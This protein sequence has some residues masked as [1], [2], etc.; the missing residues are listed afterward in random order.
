MSEPLRILAV[1]DTWCGA[2]DYGFVRAFRRTG[3]SV[4]VVSQQSFVPPGWRHPGLRALR[5]VLTPLIVRDLERRLIHEAQNFQPDLFFVFKGEFITAKAIRAVRDAGTVAINLY[6]DTGF[7]DFGPYLPVAIREYDWIFTTK[8]TGTL[9]LAENYGNSN[10]SFLPHAFDPEVHAPAI[11]SKKDICQYKCDVSFIGSYS[12]K[13]AELL[14]RLC[15]AFPAEKC[16]IWGGSWQGV[17]E[18]QHIY[19]GSPVLGREYAKAVQA[20]KI[21]LGLLFEGG[22]SALEPDKITSRT[23]A[24]PCAG[25]FM[26]HERTEEVLRYFEEGQEAAFFD[27]PEE[28]I[29]KIKY[30]LS[31]EDERAA[32]A[33]AGRRRCLS[34]GYSIDDLAKTVLAKY[35]ELRSK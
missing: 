23:F 10:A 24:I 30:Y 15:K 7:A 9:D 1:S 21:N 22:A 25:G 2:N 20:S 16:C 29:D 28:M 27:G 11:L 18:A 12:P 33:E 32:I 6:P 34:S 5:R 3:H 14:D 35:A 8:P 26:L 31:H 4:L 13:K 19:R 17:T